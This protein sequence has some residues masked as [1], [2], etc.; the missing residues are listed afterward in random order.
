[1]RRT[2]ALDLVENAHIGQNSRRLWAQI[3]GADLV[4]RKSGAIEH[5]H[6][7]TILRQRPGGGGARRP[8]TDDDYFRVSL[9]THYPMAR[10]TRWNN[11]MYRQCGRGKC[12]TEAA[13]VR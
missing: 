3:L 7:D 12:S 6:V 13:R 9:L 2:A 5:Q 4:A 10:A 11:P 8:P 1:M